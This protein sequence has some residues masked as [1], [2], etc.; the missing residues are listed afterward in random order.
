LQVIVQTVV[1]AHTGVHT[2]RSPLHC[3]RLA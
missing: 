2:W 3:T 1:Q